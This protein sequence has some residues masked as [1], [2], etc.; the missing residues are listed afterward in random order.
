MRRIGNGCD[1]TAMLSAAG[2]LQYLDGQRILFQ[3]SFPVKDSPQ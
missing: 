2:A 3:K 1:N